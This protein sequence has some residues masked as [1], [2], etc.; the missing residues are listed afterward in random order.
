MRRTDCQNA[1]G[2]LATLA[3]SLAG[4]T[5]RL[6]EFHSIPAYSGPIVSD[7]LVFTTETK[8]KKREVVRALDRKTGGQLSI[9]PVALEPP[10]TTR[11]SDSRRGHGE[12][13]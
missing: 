1:S 6:G 8:D 5:F 11:S 13:A 4:E 7:T 10:A 3:S 9:Q 2:P 12:A